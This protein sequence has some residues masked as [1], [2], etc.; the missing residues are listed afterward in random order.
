LRFREDARPLGVVQNRGTSQSYRLERVVG[1]SIIAPRRTRSA[2][3]DRPWRATAEYA[4]AASRRRFCASSPTRFSEHGI[5]DRAKPGR[6][7][8]DGCAPCLQIGRRNATSGRV[9]VG[10]GKVRYC[11]WRAREGSGKID[12]NDPLPTFKL[13]AA[14]LFCVRSMLTGL[15]IRRN[16]DVGQQPGEEVRN[17]AARTRGR[18]A[19]SIRCPHQACRRGLGRQ[20][21]MAEY[22]ANRVSVR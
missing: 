15:V 18:H 21:T 12:V 16:A 8:C 14:L 7:S 19:G 3:L 1:R 11:G 13:P 9:S 22:R 17:E 10:R 2:H 4:I 5:A 6:R 20:V